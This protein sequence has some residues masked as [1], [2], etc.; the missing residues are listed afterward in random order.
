MIPQNTKRT[1]SSDSRTILI[2]QLR[3]RGITDERV[4]SA[5][6]V[7]PR[8][9]FIAP[10]LRTKAYEDTALPI[11]NQQ[12]ISQPFTVAAMTQSLH[13][14]PGMRVLEIGTGSGYQAAVLAQLG[15][16]VVTIERHPVLSGKAR[17]T[18][19]KLGYTNVECRVGDGTIGYS[20]KAPYD[21]ILVTAGAPDVPQTLA[22]QLAIGGRLI[23][24][25]GTKTDQRMYSVL[26]NGEEDWKAHDLGPFIF[27]P[28]I[29]IEGWADAGN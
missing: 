12:T 21:G 6:S 5:M 29:G 28:L 1:P 10:T 25:V 27:V 19:A 17:T 16:H 15:A 18:L 20:G 11:D 23:I 3:Q 9:E 22:R 13:V 4:L 14:T 7:I 8:E 24:P 26:R 2:D